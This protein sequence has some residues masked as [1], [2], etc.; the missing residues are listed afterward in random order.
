[1]PDRPTAPAPLNGVKTH[2]LSEHALASLDDLQA[3]PRP[4]AQF[5]PGVVNRLMRE[6]LVE[7]V[8][9]PS[10]FKTHKGRAIPHLRITDSGRDRVFGARKC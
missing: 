3:G 2:P 8:D 4:A 10:P 1:M 5:N 7:V 9:L 6:D